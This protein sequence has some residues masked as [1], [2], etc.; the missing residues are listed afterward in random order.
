MRLSELERIRFTD[1]RHFLVAASGAIRRVLVDHARTKNAEKR[2][3]DSERVT[4][5]GLSDASS[6]PGAGAEGQIDLLALDEALARLAERDERKARVVE[7]RYFGGLTIEE[8]SRALDV[9]TTT[10]E[11]DW[12]FAKSWLRRALGGGAEA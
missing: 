8:T 2:G 9:G 5:S 10:V 12:A 4:L 3:G 7:L 11:D 1:E 6:T